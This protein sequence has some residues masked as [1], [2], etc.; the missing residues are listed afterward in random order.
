MLPVATPE[1]E[2]QAFIPRQN[3]IEYDVS[4]SLF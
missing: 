3:D 4:F 1:G 2:F